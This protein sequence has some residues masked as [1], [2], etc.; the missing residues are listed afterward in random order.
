MM[1]QPS[2]NFA[3]KFNLRRYDLDVLR[4]FSAVVPDVDVR[5]ASVST[6]DQV[7]WCGLQPVFA[8]QARN[9][10]SFALGLRLNA[11]V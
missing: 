9:E 5:A 8:S 3:F 7:G 1:N 4:E 6:V 2:S 11:R 10:T